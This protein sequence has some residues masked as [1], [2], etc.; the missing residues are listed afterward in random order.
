MISEKMA[1][2][3]NR[4]M[5]RELYSAYFYLGMASYAASIDLKGFE[6]WFIIQIREEQAHARKFYDYLNSQDAR[7]ILE[8][9]EAPPQ[10][11]TSAIDLFERTLKHE[12]KV[13]QLIH[14]LVEMAQTDNDKETE[15]FL[16]WFIEEQKEEEESATGVLQRIK[17]ATD[18]DVKSGLAVVDSELARRS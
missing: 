7:V 9:I 14:N 16:Q 13:T 12:K 2:S 17:D 6:N 3:L 10:D 18:K 15:K 4:Q 1:K 5:N 11:F 8:G